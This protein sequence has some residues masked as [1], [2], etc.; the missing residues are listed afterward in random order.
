MGRA[1]PILL[2]DLIVYAIQPVSIRF[3]VLDTG[4]YV[5]AESQTGITRWSY[6]YM[7]RVCHWLRG[8][9]QCIFAISVSQAHQESLGQN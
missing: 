6:A 3:L 2:E 8:G 5:W 1:D 4:R 9:Y 7:I